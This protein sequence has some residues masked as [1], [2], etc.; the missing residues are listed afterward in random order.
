[1]SFGEITALVGENGN[2]KTTLLRIVA[3]QLKETNGILRYPALQNSHRVNRLD[4]NVIKPQIAYIPQELPRWSG[5]LIDNL[6]FAAAAHGIRGDNNIF[7]VEYILNRLGLEDYKHATWGSISGGFKMRFALAKALLWN[8]K[9]IVLDEP[10]ANLDINTQMTFLDD[11][12]DIAN[13]M[14]SPKSILL[15]S[16]HLHEV[17][18]IADKI[19]FVQNGKAVFN[20]YLR[21]LGKVRSCNYFEICCDLSTHDLYNRLSDNFSHIE[22]FF[23]IKGHYVL[24]L[25]KDFARGNVLQILIRYKVDVTLFRDIS[26]STRSF[27]LHNPNES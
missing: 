16:Q 12:R 7:E 19:V 23:I 11:L 18:A 4:Y 10:L 3:G 17:E 2:G 6:H 1:L 22:I 9:I 26:F 21:E 15:S 14:I 25:P 27:F 24:K 8:P 20:N 5:S 13:Y